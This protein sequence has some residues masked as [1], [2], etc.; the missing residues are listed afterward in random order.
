MGK[1]KN[2]QLLNPNFF[3]NFRICFSYHLL[4]LLLGFWENRNNHGEKL[5]LKNSPAK[6]EWKKSIFVDKI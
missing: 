4:Y 2:F 3:E 1:S 6:I 5:R